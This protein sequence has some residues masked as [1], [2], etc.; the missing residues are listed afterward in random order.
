MAKEIFEILEQIERERG[1]ETKQLVGMIETAVASV[2][3]KHF[4]LSEPIYVKIDRESGEMETYMKKLVVEK[5][6]DSLV[7]IP[8]EEAQKIQ[9]QCKLG[10]EIK[11]S[12]PTEHLS[13]IAAQMAKQ[14]II[15]HIR[16]KERDNLYTEFKQREGSIVTGVVQRF[17][18][19]N[20]ILDLGKI[21]AILPVR[22]QYSRENYQ[23]RQRIKVYILKVE[24]TAKGPRIIVSRTH[25]DL[26]RA[27]FELE[28]PEISDHT[29][30]IKDVV[31]EPGVRAK[32]AVTS[33]NEKV[34]PVGSCV[35][36]KGSRVHAVMDEL[37]EEKIDLILWSPVPETYVKNALSPATVKSVTLDT[38]N[39]TALVIVDDDMLSLAI[40]KA[41][42][43]VRLAARLT[44][45]HIDIRK[46][47]EIEKEDLMS[48]LRKLDGVGPKTA[49][50]LIDAKFNTS[51]KISRIEM[52]DLLKISGIGKKAAE[53]IYKQIRSRSQPKGK[54]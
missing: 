38:K 4:R 13:R 47:S 49:Q 33:H 5:M 15:Q 20:V 22:E 30:E 9:S 36:V 21:D 1:I 40:G 52:K 12:L 31:R 6:T 45:W 37:H 26:V 44:K 29:V 10:E 39:K 46:E 16:E 2:F 51:G 53:K 25:P 3:K 8:L 41:G 14:V 32:I 43:N 34:E 11:I 28:V 18:K 23:V 48:E 24:E 50:S 27:L 19:K 54:T 42:S 17:V 7:Q 35:G